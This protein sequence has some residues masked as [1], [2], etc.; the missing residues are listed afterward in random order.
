VNRDQFEIVARRIRARAAAELAELPVEDPDVVWARRAAMLAD[1][2][3]MQPVAPC[4][5]RYLSGGV[6]R[7]RPTT[8]GEPH[9]AATQPQPDPARPLP[10]T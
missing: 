8:T 1:V 7:W 2:Y 5:A 3:G 4:N 9:D 6:W 10:P